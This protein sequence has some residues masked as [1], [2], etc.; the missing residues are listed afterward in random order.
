MAQQQH[1]FDMTEPE[2]R[3]E[4]IALGFEREQT[5][6]NDSELTT[7]LGHARAHPRPML[8]GIPIL[9]GVS[10][11][12]DTIRPWLVAL[13]CGEKHVVNV[14]ADMGQTESITFSILSEADALTKL[15]IPNIPHRVL[16]CPRCTAPM[17][18]YYKRTSSDGYCGI[19][20]AHHICNNADC[21]LNIERFYEGYGSIFD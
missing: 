9:S 12:I 19:E 5:N 7:L 8:A 20:Y 15:S 21:R 18:L 6:K 11:N 1:I 4:L 16:K 10:E 17:H 14:A 3:R 2:K 13:N